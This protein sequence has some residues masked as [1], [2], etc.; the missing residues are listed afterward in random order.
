MIRQVGMFFSNGVLVGFAE[1]SK[2]K[3]PIK[4]KSTTTKFTKRIDS[5]IKQKRLSVGGG[6]RRSAWLKIVTKI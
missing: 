4:F 6:V 3:S 5:T 2:G 1:I